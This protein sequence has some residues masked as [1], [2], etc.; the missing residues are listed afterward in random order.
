MQA[1]RSDIVITQ[2]QNKTFPMIQMSMSS[3]SNISAK[4]FE[5]LSNIKILKLKLLKCGK[6]KQK[7]YQSL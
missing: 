1:N 7:P 3:D 6:W 4:E 5:N 2:K